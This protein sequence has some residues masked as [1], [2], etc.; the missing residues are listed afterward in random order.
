M[1]TYQ[2][3]RNRLTSN[4]NG[5]MN[6]T[7][8]VTTPVND[9]QLRL[10]LL[11]GVDASTDSLSTDNSLN[12]LRSIINANNTAA[13]EQARINREFQQASAREAMDFESA[14]AEKNRNW[15]S[16]ANKIAMDFSA[17]EAQ[18]NRDF[19]TNAN[20]IAMDFNKAEAQLSRD[21]QERMSNTAYQRAMSDLKAAGLNPILAY[22]N[23][24][25]AV[26]SGAM[27]S[28][29]SSSG[30]AA[31]GVSSSGAQAS[32]RSASGSQASTDMSTAAHLISTLLSNAKDMN[33]AK[34]NAVFKGVDSVAKLVDAIIPA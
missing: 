7:T 11:S 17:A 21:W 20:Q 24:G 32:G 16:E 14:E 4:I 26:T 8:V 6:G 15:Q 27:A 12:D 10:N 31:A 3:A 13:A 29:V 2:N 33:I 23:G 34:L 9:P 25:A 18:K 30:S 28:G 1:S 19:Q 22:S 5:I